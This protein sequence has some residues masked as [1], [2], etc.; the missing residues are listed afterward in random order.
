MAIGMDNGCTEQETQGLAY[1]RVATSASGK[2]PDI[3]SETL[4]FPRYS[5]NPRLGFYHFL[6][7][8]WG[9]GEL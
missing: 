5:Y 3:Y 2:F 7:Q 1:H 4:N 9:L 6:E 8:I